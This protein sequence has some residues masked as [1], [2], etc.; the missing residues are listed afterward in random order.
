M[1]LGPEALLLPPE[2]A[3]GTILGEINLARIYVAAMAG[4]MVSA[5]LAEAGRHGS[6]RRT[7]GA[8]LTDHQAWRLALARARCDLD[9]TEALV[10][11]AA[12]AREGREVQRLAASA[13]VVATACARTHLPALLHAMGA[14]GLDPDL[15]FARHHAA[16]PLLEL[17]DGATE[18]LLER[19]AR[20]TRLTDTER[21]EP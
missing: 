7:F 21:P 10:D 20:L 6:R 3:L 1:A 16:T 4:A 11:R 18:M 17:V 2:T 8:N 12:A 15:C 9:A 14:R 13:K 19:V 5:A